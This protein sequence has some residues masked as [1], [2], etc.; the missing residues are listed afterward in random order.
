MPTKFDGT[1]TEERALNAQITLQRAADAVQ[2]NCKTFREADLT[3]SQFGVLDA[4]YH[5]GP[6]HQK[7]L[8][9]KTLKSDANTTTVVDNMEERELVRRER[10]P[11]DRRCYLVHLTDRGRELFASIFPEHVD[12][13]VEVFSVLSAKEQQSLIELCK[14]LGT[15]DPDRDEETEPNADGGE[16]GGKN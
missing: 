8:G 4:L 13:I 3:A 9:E 2:K 1:E 6:M 7:D 14:K 15:Y 12:R 11:E 5:L 10:D 16:N